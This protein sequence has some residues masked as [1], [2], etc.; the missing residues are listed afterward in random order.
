MSDKPKRFLVFRYER[1]EP[2]GGWNDMK[3]D[4]DTLDDAIESLPKKMGWDEYADIVD[5]KTGVVRCVPESW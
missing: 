2:S 3:G 5:L 4:Y 1:Y